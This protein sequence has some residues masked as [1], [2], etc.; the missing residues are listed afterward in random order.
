[1]I[2]FSPSESGSENLFRL[3][4][5]VSTIGEIL[6]NHV[7]VATPKVIVEEGVNTSIK[8]TPTE[9]IEFQGEV[10][11]K[12]NRVPMEAAFV[13]K[14]S[15]LAPQFQPGSLLA[16]LP[17]LNETYGLKLSTE[18]I[19]EK[20]L[21]GEGDVVIEAKAA[22]F[23]FVPGTQ[24]VLQMI[25]TMA[26]TFGVTDLNGFE[27]EPYLDMSTTFAVKDLSGFTAA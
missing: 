11:L 16:Q 27:R 18:D 12:Y 10:V 23:V 9:L 26:N 22:S 21:T 5:A 14:D 17:L 19:V 13:G 3:L 15:V 7:D 8:V 6:P 24:F 25:P 2:T 1:M 4:N 20:T